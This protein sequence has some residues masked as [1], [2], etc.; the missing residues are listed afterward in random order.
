MF[1]CEFCE[2]SKNSFSYRTPLVTSEIFRVFDFSIRVKIENSDISELSSFL[3]QKKEVHSNLE[4]LKNCPSFPSFRCHYKGE[5]RKFGNLGNFHLPQTDK[6]NQL[7]LQGF[8]Q[9]PSF[10]S[11]RFLYKDQNRKLENIRNFQLPPAKQL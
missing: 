2:I 10:T 11:F 6:K 8:R 5:N 9:F 7:T 1:S 3:K 4:A